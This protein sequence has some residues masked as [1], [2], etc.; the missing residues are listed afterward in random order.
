[1]KCRSLDGLAADLTASRFSDGA[2]MADDD[3]SSGIKY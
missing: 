1:M 2:A 3:R